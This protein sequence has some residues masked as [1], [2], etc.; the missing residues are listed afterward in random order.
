M[1]QLVGAWERLNHV[2]LRPFL[3]LSSGQQAEESNKNLKKTLPQGV[4]TRWNS[5]FDEIN[6]LKD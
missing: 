6:V 4:Q 2:A 1:I 3:P 5:Y